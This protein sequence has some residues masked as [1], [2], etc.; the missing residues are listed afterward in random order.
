MVPCDFD[1]DEDIDLFVANDRD[2][3]HL[4]RNDTRP[5]GVISLKDVALEAGVATDGQGAIESCMGADWG[6]FD[7]DGDFDLFVSNMAF[8]TNTLYRR[9]PDATFSDRTDVLGLGRPS[10]MWVGS[11][12]KFTDQDLDG[13]LDLALLNG[14]VL[15]NVE[16]FDS[17]QR[18]AQQ[19]VLFVQGGDGRFAIAADA[20]P[21]FAERHVARGLA[22]GDLDG[23][24]DVDLVAVHRS[25]GPELLE[26]LAI[27]AGRAGPAWIGVDLRGKGGNSRAIGA[28]VECVAGG[29]RQME[30]VRGAGSYAAWNDTRIVFGLGAHRGPVNLR[31]RWPGGLTT[32]H[33]DVATGRYLALS[34]P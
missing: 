21:Y 15:D 31:V 23:D 3:N 33:A 2:L 30:E 7:R 14:H 4:W 27:G 25:E 19:A 1:D 8:E 10:L 5:G 24:G 18:F 13:D 22:A 34:A 29:R 17:T 20:G 28:R 32:E 16:R 11:G 12:A 9:E 6:D 26:N